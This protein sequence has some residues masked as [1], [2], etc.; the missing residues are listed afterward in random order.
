VRI[1]RAKGVDDEF[2]AGLP[3]EQA[4]DEMDRRVLANGKTEINLIHGDNGDELLRTVTPFIA[5]KNYYGTNC[6]QCHGV[7]EGTVLGVAS[8]VID[9]KEDMD[10]IKAINYWV[11]GGQIILQIILF[12]VITIIS[13]RL[14][15]QLG[16]EPTLAIE[17]ANKISNGDLSTKIVVADDDTTSLIA[18]MKRMSEMI[19]SMIDDT[20]MLAKAAMEGDL[21]TRADV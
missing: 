14:L 19:H 4:T 8:V 13:R 18:S 11:W 2:P 20:L 1:V 21:T 5:E 12:I 7:D 16:G 9:I 17:I 6:L 15:R 10:S 3:E